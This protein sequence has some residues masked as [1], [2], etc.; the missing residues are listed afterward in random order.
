MTKKELTE[1]LA[2]I[3]DDTNIGINLWKEDG[4][5]VVDF[6]KS[7]QQ[8]EGEPEKFVKVADGREFLLVGYADHCAAHVMP[9]K[10]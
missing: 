9:V 4:P 2:G 8:Q 10:G 7:I 1:I 5:H 6:H 3:P